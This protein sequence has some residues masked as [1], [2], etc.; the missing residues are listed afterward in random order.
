MGTTLFPLDRSTNSDQRVLFPEE[1]GAKMM[2]KLEDPVRSGL[3]RH[4]AS[5]EKGNANAAAVLALEAAP[6]GVGKK[7]QWD[8][9]GNEELVKA[10][11]IEEDDPYYVV[12]KIIS[13]RGSPDNLEDMEILVRRTD[14]TPKDDSYISWHAA[15]HL[16]ELD[17]YMRKKAD[18]FREVFGDV[19]RTGVAV[20]AKLLPEE[21]EWVVITGLS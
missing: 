16:E 14:Y 20:W 2:V 8:I 19:A 7:R 10:H 17:K 4:A 9:S 3:G 15:E 13:H 6:E 1:L 18:I 12:E 5:K 11:R 21:A